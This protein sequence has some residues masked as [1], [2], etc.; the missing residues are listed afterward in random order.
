MT[1]RSVKGMTM[2]EKETPSSIPRADAA[3]RILGA[4]EALFSQHGFDAV[5]VNAIAERAG[6]SKAN[7]FHHFNSKD[8]LYLAV[9]KNCCGKNAALKNIISG[10]APLREC[11]PRFAESHLTTI[12]EQEHVSRLI[13]RELLKDS[14]ER[15]EELAQ[16]IF[17]PDFARFVEI[18]R[19]RQAAGE[20]RAEIDPAM[21]AVLLIAADVF[22]FEARP[23]LQHFPDVKFAQQ[24]EQY[25]RMLADIL[26]HGILTVKQNNSNKCQPG[27]RDEPE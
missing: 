26:M 15:A 23:V 14:P 2:T 19:Q 9:I 12:L 3:E 10:P 5:S 22:F 20:L 18:L 11:L 17:G 1:D 25:S 27:P 8:A 16:Q 6:V 13:A 24:P 4:A 7:V 21:V